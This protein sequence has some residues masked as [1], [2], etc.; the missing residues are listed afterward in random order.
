MGTAR[1]LQAE[2]HRDVG[3]RA[4]G[5][6]IEPKLI[7]DPVITAIAKRVNKTSAQ[8]LLGWALQRGT[9]PLTTSTNT[10]YINENFDVSALPNDAINEIT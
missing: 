10:R 5:H 1:L 6:G 9:A 2:W 4:L 8:V 3:V 7:D